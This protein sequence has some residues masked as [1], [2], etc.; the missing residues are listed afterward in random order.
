MGDFE[1]VSNVMAF[2]VNLSRG[3][4]IALLSAFLAYL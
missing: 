4:A 1:I 2:S 3:G